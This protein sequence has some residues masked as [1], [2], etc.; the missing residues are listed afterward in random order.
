MLAELILATLRGRPATLCSFILK[1]LTVRGNTGFD[2]T[3]SGIEPRYPD[4]H[5]HLTKERRWLLFFSLVGLS[6]ESLLADW[7][8]TV[9]SFFFFTVHF[10]RIW[11]ICPINVAF[12]SVH[13]FDKNMSNQISRIRVIAKN[14]AARAASIPSMAFSFSLRVCFSSTK[15]SLW[16]DQCLKLHFK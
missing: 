1:R 4:G 13:S 11:P 12:F 8:L 9:L 7:K 6:I 10:S 2:W 15:K 5:V 16:S 14:F 3:I